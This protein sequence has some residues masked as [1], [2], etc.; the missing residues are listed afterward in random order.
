M[1]TNSWVC[2]TKILSCS[3]LGKAQ[4]CEGSICDIDESDW[5]GA[6]WDHPRMLQIHPLAVAACMHIDIQITKFA[7]ANDLS[8]LEGRDEAPFFIF[9]F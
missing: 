7:Y 3:I 6:Q 4:S 2:P 9:V 1:C 5:A 8:A